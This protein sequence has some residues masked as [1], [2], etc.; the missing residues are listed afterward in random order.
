MVFNRLLDIL[1]GGFKINVSSEVTLLVKAC[2]YEQRYPT[3]Q[4]IIWQVRWNHRIIVVREPL[5][6][7]FDSGTEGCLTP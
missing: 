4:P 1:N 2:L 6:M 3:S 7:L 5:C